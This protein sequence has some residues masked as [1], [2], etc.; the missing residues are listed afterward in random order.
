MT[1]NILS[2]LEASAGRFPDKVFL[3]DKNHAVTFGD[4]LAAARRMGTFLAK[5]MGKRNAPVA[6]YIDRS[7]ESVLMF[8]GVVCS[9]NF[10]V[11][12]NASLPEERVRVMLK[13]IQPVAILGKQREHEGIYHDAPFYPFDMINAEEADGE[14]LEAI[15][16]ESLDTDPLYAIFTSGSTGV[17]KAVLVA[18]N[19]MVDL[20]ENF[21]EVFDLDETAVFGNQAQFDFD[22]SC[23]DI[24][25]A[26]LS[27]GTVEI[28]PKKL[29]SFPVDLVQYL[30][31]RR[32]SHAFWVVAAMSIVANRKGMKN[33]KPLYLKKVMFSG[34]AIPV[35]VLSYWRENLPETVMYN[36]YG[37]TEITCNCTYFKVVR[38]Y[39]VDEN[40]P[41]GIPFRN[42]GI[43]LLRENGTV[44]GEGETGELC[45]RGTCLALGY[46]NNPEKTA[47]SFIQNPLN[48]YYPE[49][50]Y[51]TGDLARYDGEGQLVFCGRKDS[52]IKHMG[53]RIELGDI[54]SAANALEQVGRVCCLYD[55]P[56]DAIVLFYEAGE[57]LSRE[58]LK[59]LKAKLPPYMFPSRYIRLNVMPE[60]YHSKIDRKR[61]A[62]EYL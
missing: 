56:R 23:K 48:P 1:T 2:Y 13:S 40:V 52:Q 44:A 9:G 30:N 28:I 17:P 26:L 3:A 32:I 41:I 29:F 39:G 50:I 10:Y 16:R 54:E 19:S 42:T 57:D 55:K 25:C 59:M 14:V 4:V 22:I 18:H 53:Y 36:L 35:K 24:Y 46:Y 11:P 27:G 20:A 33:S 61:L 31:D 45:V 43:L 8:L 58:F 62:K 51:R 15:R 37:P 12:I 47:E 49:R 5:R 34:E 21:R 6:V 38:E 7:L 60:N